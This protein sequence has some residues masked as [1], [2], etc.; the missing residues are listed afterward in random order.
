MYGVKVSASKVVFSADTGAEVDMSD[1]SRVVAIAY[2]ADKRAYI[3]GI[4]AAT[5]TGASYNYMNSRVEVARR[6]TG[7]ALY[8]KGRVLAFRA[9]SRTLTADEIK[10]NY[11]VDKRRFGL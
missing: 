2:T 4:S 3:N 8:Y 6:H 7:N 11:E 9:H 5:T 10:A 1:P